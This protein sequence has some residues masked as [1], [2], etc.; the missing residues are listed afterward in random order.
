MASALT[1][2]QRRFEI[3]VVNG[4]P[5]INGVPVPDFI[6]DCESKG[7]KIALEHLLLVAEQV[8]GK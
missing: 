4:T 3:A 6:K 5:C 8:V 7:D 2:N 1:I